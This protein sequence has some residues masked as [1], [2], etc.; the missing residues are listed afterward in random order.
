MVSNIVYILAILLS[1]ERHF[2]STKISTILSKIAPLSPYIYR[3][4]F[5]SVYYYKKIVFVVMFAY[6]L[7]S[8]RILEHVVFTLACMH[9][10]S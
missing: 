1:S 4:K 8:P 9:V 6:L 3:S 10:Y 2:K 5:E 7:S